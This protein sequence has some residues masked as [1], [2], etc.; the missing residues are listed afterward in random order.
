VLL[1]YDVTDRDS[2]QWLS[3][4]RDQVAEY[5]GDINS[6]VIAVVG[7]KVDRTEDRVVST[8]EGA[9]SAKNLGSPLFFETSAKTVS[10]IWCLLSAR[11]Q[12]ISTLR[13]IRA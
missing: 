2:F 11:K 10:L 9:E 4:W 6:V 5:V 13:I 1:V 12:L 3:K 8:E 7:N